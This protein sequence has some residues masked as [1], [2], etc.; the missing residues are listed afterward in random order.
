MDVSAA[1]LSATGAASEVASAKLAD[2]FDTF[3]TLLTT[4]LKNQD[5]LEPTDSNQ[6]VQQLVQFSQ[7]EQAI[8][9]NKSLE[10]LLGLQTANQAAAAIGYMGLTV[11]AVGNIVPLEDGQAKFAYAL[12]KKSDGT[13]IVISD[14]DGKLVRT[15]DGE[16]ETGKHVFVWDGL[17]NDGEPVPE[18]RYTIAVNAFDEN[19]DKIEAPV[20]I[21]GKVTGVASG[22]EGTLLSLG[23]VNVPLAEVLSVSAQTGDEGA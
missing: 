18:G 6:F 14:S 5:P 13:V 15:V 11:E 1:G 7:V 12:D 10:K 19:K 8:A 21:F 16:T 2:N 17:D 3:L 9:S 20:S 22:E 4:Q 23:Q